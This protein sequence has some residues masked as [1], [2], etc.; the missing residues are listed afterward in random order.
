ME[1]YIEKINSL[2]TK[3]YKKYLSEEK[4]TILHKIKLHLDDIYYNTGESSVEDYKYDLLKETLTIRD[5]D[6]VPPVGAKLRQG[7]NR[8]QL[9]YWL[10]SAD[11]ITPQQPEVLNRWVRDNKSKNYVVSSKLDGVS[12]LLVRENNKINL[13]T[14]G[15][16]EIGADISYLTNYFNIP[17]LSEDIAVRGELIMKKGD[18]NDKHSESY[19]NPRNMVSGLISGKTARKGLEDIHFVV[20]EIVGDSMPKPSEQLKK[21]NKLGFEVVNFE[22]ISDLTIDTLSEIYPRFR[23]ESEYELDGIIVQSDSP[24]DRNIS[25]NPDYMFAFKMLLDDA[26][27]ET[28]V[29]EIEW[30]MSKWGQL[31]PVVIVDPVETGGITMTRATAHNAKYVVDNNLGRGAKIKI[32]RSKEVIPYIVEVVKQAKKPDMPEIDYIW[33]KNEVNIFAKEYDDTMCVKLISNFFAKL[34]IKHVSEATVKKMFENG[35]DDLIKIVS[36]DKKRLLQIPE[37]KEKSAER[38]YTNIHNGL[39]DV[40]I[41]D[42]V[43]A[44]G[45]L[46]FGIGSKKMNTLLRGIPDIL[47]MYKE[48]T[49]EQLI[50]EIIKVEGFSDLTAKKI[51][52]NL[53]YADLLI[54]KLSKYAKFKKEKKVSQKLQGQKIVMTGFRDK[55]LEEDIISRGGNVTGSVSKNTTILI[56]A[57]KGG[58]LSG[59]LEKAESLGIPI[60]EK[61]EFIRQYIL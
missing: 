31:K 49:E 3:E 47:T 16:G 53:R 55:K 15:D 35:L 59:K 7:E 14:R 38:I 48:K 28:E 50:A 52:H 39:Q 13:Y 24:Y 44:S 6:Y 12:C 40:K 20:Y 26:I 58:K 8:T 21:L 27:F 32:T 1:K 17:K 42:V 61:D 54:K 2:S 36:A 25:G 51:V 22:I 60:Y 5:P 33:D 23:E 41:P 57:K 56:V 43:G 29:K 9:P 37:F 45:V 10:G 46:G 18:F 30:N 34:G 19:K 11:K 4:L